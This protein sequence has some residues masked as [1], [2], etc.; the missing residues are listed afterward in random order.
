[1]FPRS[2]IP[3]PLLPAARALYYALFRFQL[4]L[5]CW[6]ADRSKARDASELPLPPALL[7]YR[8]SELLGRGDFLTIGAG[9]ARLIEEQSRSMG[10]DLARC[11]R[12][13][14]F[15]CGCG[16][17][18]RWLL[19]AFPSVEFCG[20]DVDREAIEWCSRNL[21]SARFVRNGPLPPL[22]FPDARFDLIYCLSVFT[23]LD[24][25]AQDIWFSELRRLLAP[26]GVLLLSVH[27]EGAAKALDPPGLA[28]L[29]TAGFVHRRSPKLKGIVPD[30][31]QTSWHS[32]QYI[33]RRLSS[34]FQDVRYHDVAGSPQAI[35]TARSRNHLRSNDFT[36]TVYPL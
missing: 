26:D 4:R 17:T 18:L 35:V 33:V 24:E 22:P 21:P 31:Y 32:E 14:D 13:L 23:H 16:R 2:I 27:G 9:C 11:R 1:M 36:S 8:V 29:R 25:P 7:R 34:S 19:A 12:I 30:W 15:G 5:R 3:A 20:A 10:L 28:A 6:L